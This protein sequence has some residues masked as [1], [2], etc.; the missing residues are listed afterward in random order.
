MNVYKKWLELKQS[1]FD[2][3]NR[4]ENTKQWCRRRGLEE[5]RFYEITKLRN[6]FQDL[7]QDCGLIEMMEEEML[8]SSDRALRNGELKQLRDIRRDHRM[9]STGKRKLLKSDPWGLEDD[10]DDDVVDI[11]DVEF[12]L[13]HN[14]NKIQVF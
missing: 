3:R 14:S 1:N 9:K 11:R 2:R 6:Q 13:S 7:L 8:S 4:H 10:L 5:Q 12:R